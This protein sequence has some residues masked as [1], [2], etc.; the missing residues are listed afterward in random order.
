MCRTTLLFSSKKFDGRI[1]RDFREKW[2]SLS[3]KSILQSTV[4]IPPP[5]RFFF[6]F[7]NGEDNYSFSPFFYFLISL[8]FLFSLSFCFSFPFF[9]SF[10]LSFF[11]FYFSSHFFSLGISPPIWSIIDRMGQRRKL[12]PHCLTHTI[13]VVHTFPS[14]FLISYFFLLHHTPMW[15]IVSHPFK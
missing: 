12:P 8:C 15:L 3:R 9:F 2:L 13:C 14:I 5:A 10:F 4:R 6:S 11:S 7:S 1:N